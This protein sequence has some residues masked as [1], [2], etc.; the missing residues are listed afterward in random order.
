MENIGFIGL[1]IMGRLMAG[2]LIDGGHE[3]HLMSRSGVPD[4]LIEKGGKSWKT[5]G[6]VAAAADV[7]ITMIPDTPHVEDVLFGSD[8]VAEGFTTGKVA[9]IRAFGSSCTKKT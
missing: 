2:H 4:D 5:A 8:G 3:V 9:S 7:I 6:E 1:G